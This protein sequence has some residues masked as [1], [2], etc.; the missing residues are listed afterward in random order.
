MP[1]YSGLTYT[2]AFVTHNE[3]Q[4]YRY[5]MI[6]TNK[7]G[8]DAIPDIYSQNKNIFLVVCRETNGNVVVFE[9]CLSRNNH[10]KRIDKYWLDLDPNYKYKAIQRG[11]IRDEF[12]MLDNYAY[13]IV[14]TNKEPQ[15]WTFH[16]K[17]FPSQNLTVE[18]VND[19]VSC[20]TSQQDRVK[21]Y[22]QV[23]VHHI[24]VYLKKTYYH[25][26]D[27]IRIIGLETKN[28]KTISFDITNNFF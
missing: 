4:N 24:M 20:F 28:Y 25:V 6:E 9:A 1:I 15:K 11:T 7:Y 8:V 26:V 17:R 22:H 14:V 19:K 2:D 27:F 18:V 12:K 13:G 10:I 21:R 3:Y 5:K 16:F 23:K